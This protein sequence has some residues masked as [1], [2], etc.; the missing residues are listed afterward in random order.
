MAKKRS[1]IIIATNTVFFILFFLAKSNYTAQPSISDTVKIAAP[2]VSPTKIYKG[3]N[4]T[5]S[6]YYTIEKGDNLWKIAKKFNTT[7]EE[8]LEINKSSDG[9]P[10]LIKPGI[11]IKVC[12]SSNS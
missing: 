12:K 2:M 9:N 7:I 1:L 5:K 10:L 11:Q 4:L 8:L 6:N 3:D